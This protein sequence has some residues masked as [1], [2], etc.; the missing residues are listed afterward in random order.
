MGLGFA[1]SVPVIW[2]NFLV[3]HL[4]PNGRSTNTT[5]AAVGASLEAFDSVSA[6]RH[7]RVGDA[8]LTPG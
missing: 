2:F 1:D 8:Q 6:A 4:F 3:A 7:R 5:N